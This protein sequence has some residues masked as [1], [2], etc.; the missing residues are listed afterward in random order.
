MP[1]YRQMLAYRGLGA[2]DRHIQPDYTQTTAFPQD[3]DSIKS[4]NLM[5]A[6]GGWG[7]NPVTEVEILTGS[8]SPYLVAI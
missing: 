2:I 6:A 8:N 1:R 5:E 7:S 3:L 4:S